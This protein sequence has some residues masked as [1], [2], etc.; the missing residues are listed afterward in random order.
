MDTGPLRSLLEILD[1]KPLFALPCTCKRL[2]HEVLRKRLLL[3]LEGFTQP[4]KGPGIAGIPLEVL[5]EDLSRCDR[6]LFLRN[7]APSDSRIG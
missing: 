4:E 5:A 7:A 6:C 2:P 1:S 3:Y